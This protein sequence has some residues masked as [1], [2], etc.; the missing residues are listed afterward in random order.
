M[1][2]PRLSGK[3]P[4]EDFIAFGENHPRLLPA[5]P[6]VPRGPQ[7]GCIVQRATPDADCTIPRH[8]ANPG[9]ALRANQSGVDAPA[10]GGALKLTRLK[11]RQAKSL[12]GDNDPQGERGAGQALAILFG[13]AAGCAPL[14]TSASAVNIIARNWTS[15]KAIS[16]YSPKRPDSSR[17]R[18]RLVTKSAI[19]SR[20][21]CWTRL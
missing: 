7:P 9:T 20:E 10:V 14:G 16:R 18:V 4:L 13:S 5:G 12:L 3:L 21:G 19:C 8:A 17:I 6:Y 11:P 2:G 15:R 1:N